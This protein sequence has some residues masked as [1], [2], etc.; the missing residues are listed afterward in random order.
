M[1]SL[2]LVEMTLE[3]VAAF[4][5]L[6]RM[7]LG[8]LP[9]LIAQVHEHS[10]DA[11]IL[12]MK[13]SQLFTIIGNDEF[14]IA[15]QA[16]ALALNTIY[17]VEGP[18]QPVIRLL[19]FMVAGA[20]NNNTPLDYL[21]EH[22]D[23][24][25]DI[26]YLLSD[27]PLPLVLPEHDVAMISFGV[28]D[29]DA[30][31]L[32]MMGEVVKTWPRPVLNLPRQVALCARDTL[33]SV[34]QDVQG[35]LIMPTLRI[36]RDTLAHIAC[37]CSTVSAL[38]ANG[39]Y[40]ITI[41]PL[42]SY[43]GKGL[44]KIE[45]GQELQDYL[46]RYTDSV[47]FVSF[48]KEYRSADGYYRKARIALIDGVPYVGHLAISAHWIVHYHSANMADSIEKREEEAQFMREF[49]S[50]FGQRHQQALSAIAQRLGLDYVVIDCAETPNDELLIFEI[51]NC[52]WI[53]ATDDAY[54]FGYKQAMM[55]KAF[56]AFRAMLISQL[57]CKVF[58]SM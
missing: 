41:R 26:V 25:L 5:S 16:R 18:Q 40:P 21:I 15:M 58:G 24:Q 8:E 9:A 51:D 49:D 14:A 23:I 31:I 4:A 56:D 47:F 6:G 39:T 50:S 7:P 36:D 10:G 53:H 22:S 11:A 55:Q 44:S 43:G 20:I 28:S 33:Y 45:N 48:F 52:G 57:Q 54:L 30:P 27:Q 32:A 13:L 46:N 35:L 3:P 1:Q 17:R 29:K 37:G 38:F 34:L 12:Y 2:K 19:A 42:L